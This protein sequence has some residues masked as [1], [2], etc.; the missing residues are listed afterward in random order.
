MGNWVQ[1][2]HKVARARETPETAGIEHM[3]PYKLV[4]RLVGFDFPPSD[5]K[6]KTDAR[7]MKRMALIEPVNLC[8]GFRKPGWKAELYY[9]ELHMSPETSQVTS[10]SNPIGVCT[11][12][13]SN[14]LPILTAIDTSKPINEN[15]GKIQYGRKT[16]E[17]TIYLSCKGKEHGLAVFEVKRVPVLCPDCGDALMHVAKYD[18]WYC[19]NCKKYT[20]GLDRSIAWPSEFR[21]P[22]EPAAA[23]DYW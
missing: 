1:E 21:S 20:E 5:E 4:I 14:L 19:F 12:A 16:D 15:P 10:G 6:K 17:D 13:I 23:P 18:R 2:Y 7:A 22:G 11:I 9:H 3:P 8:P